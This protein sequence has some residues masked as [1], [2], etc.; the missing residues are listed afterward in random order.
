MPHAASELDAFDKLR[1]LVLGGQK[2]GKSCSVI[3][4]APGPVYVINCDQAGALRPV[5]RRGQMLGLPKDFFVYDFVRSPNEMEKALRTAY[6]GAKAGDFQTVVL[7]TISSYSR[8]LLELML[9]KSTTASGG[10]DG[11][12][13]YPETQKRVHNTFDRMDNLAAHLIWISHYR[14]SGPTIDGQLAKQGP[15]IA[16]LLPGDLRQSL[17]AEF[18][19]IVFFE[20]AMVLSKKLGKKVERAVFHTSMEGVWGPGC[21]SLAKNDPSYRVV[22]ADIKK[23]IELFR[24]SESGEADDDTKGLITKI[25]KTKAA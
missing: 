18:Q 12:K 22:P 25:K 19:D 8:R 15:G 6:D 17:P 5:K 3:C 20:R 9:R 11:R 24:K 16:P 2:Q 4:T 21:R 1:L 10:V 23:L 13:A 14:D 7:D